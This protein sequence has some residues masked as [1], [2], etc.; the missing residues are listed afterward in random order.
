MQ[1]DN[2]FFEDVS[3]FASGAMGAIMDM[4]RE[5]D[6]LVK[7]QV[8]KLLSGMN[9]VTREEFDVVKA[10]AEKARTE[11]EALAARL[12]ALEKKQPSTN[13]KSTHSKT[14]KKS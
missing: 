10:M 11:N 13:P 3:K 7:S 4:K 6:Q 2:P 9:L 14:T 1:K 8:E 5:I 12:D